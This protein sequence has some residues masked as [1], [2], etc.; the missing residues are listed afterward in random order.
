MALDI[1][2]LLD[3]VIS[4][5]LTLGVI[6]EMNG[7][8][9][10]SAPGRACH[11]RAPLPDSFGTSQRPDFTRGRARATVTFTRRVALG[12]AARGHSMGHAVGEVTA[13]LG[14]GL[15]HSEER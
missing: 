7:H 14:R 15:V 6:D 9:P 3:G 1:D 10:K 12:A 13:A 5:A 11:G 4:H 8:E 2:T